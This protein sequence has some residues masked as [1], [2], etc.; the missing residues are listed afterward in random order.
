MTK[1]YNWNP[2]KNQKLK[3]ERAIFFE[4][5]VYHIQQGNEVDILEHPNRERYQHQKIMV[6]VINDYA[7]LVPFIETETE[8]FL[9]TIIPSRKATKKYLGK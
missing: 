6:V 7:Y 8:I 3:S 9:K 2:E 5:I 1:Y 4:E